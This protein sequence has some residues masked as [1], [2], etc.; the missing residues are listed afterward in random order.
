LVC[1]SL[2]VLLAVHMCVCVFE[3]GRVESA[4]DKD[5]ELIKSNPLKHAR[6]IFSLNIRGFIE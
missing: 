6:N 5:D 3:N 4:F 1:L 2:F